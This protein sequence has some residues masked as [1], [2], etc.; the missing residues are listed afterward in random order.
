MDKDEIRLNENLDKMSRKEGWEKKLIEDLALSSLREKRTSRRW[1]IFF[2][3]AF[4]G[5][6]VALVFLYYSPFEPGSLEKVANIVAEAKI[7]IY[8]AYATEPMEG[9]DTSLILK[10]SDDKA[11]LKLLKKK[12]KN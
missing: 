10:T 5:Y 11:A 2:K 6:L 3:L 7:N 4:L 12:H 1:G 9:G 8:Y